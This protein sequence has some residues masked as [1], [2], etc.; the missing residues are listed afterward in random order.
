MNNFLDSITSG[1]G[2]PVGQ[3]ASQFGLSPEQVRSAIGQLA[4]ALSGAVEQNAA[5]PGG[6]DALQRAVT[7]GNHARYLD[8]PAALADP[9]T[10]EDGNAILGHLLGSK[11][12]SRR[13]AGAAAQS[14][15]ISPDVLKQMLPLVATLV[16]GQL[17]KSSGGSGG[18]L[19]SVL[20]GLA[21]GGGGGSSFGSSS[22]GGAG[23]MLG[24]V[25]GKFLR[26]R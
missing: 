8:N 10:T 24:S 13:V 11:D 9:A 14:T 19:A 3:L 5:K 4:P 23:G 15:G 12:E 18:G 21:G 1:D 26:R 7:T 22:G 6:Q 25:L 16:M 20:G 2:G 17:G